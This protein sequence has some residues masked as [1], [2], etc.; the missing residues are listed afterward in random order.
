MVSIIKVL[1]P[2]DVQVHTKNPSAIRA[3]VHG[4][5]IVATRSTVMQQIPTR[6][7]T[8]TT[9]PSVPLD[10]EGLYISVIAA[11]DILKGQPVYITSNGLLGLAGGPQVADGLATVGALQGNSCQYISEGSITLDAWLGIT[12]NA[13]LSPGQVYYLGTAGELTAQVPTSGW[14]QY[15]GVGVS[16]S[17]LDVEIRRPIQLI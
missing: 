5:P 4:S 3:P 9:A 15:I 2:R 6:R 12:G 17:T 16:A 11:E 14:S 8:V 13:V 7:I 10:T 1:S